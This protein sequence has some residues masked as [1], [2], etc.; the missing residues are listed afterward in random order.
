MTTQGIRLRNRGW[1]LHPVSTLLEVLESRPNW[2][3]K[4]WQRTFRDVNDPGAF[5][6]WLHMLHD[7]T[8]WS[9]VGEGYWRCGLNRFAGLLTYRYMKIFTCK[10]GEIDAL[11]AV[12][13]PE[14]LIEH[15]KELLPR[16]L[17]RN[18][19]ESE[20][21]DALKS[22]D[23]NPARCVSMLTSRRERTLVEKT[24]PGILLRGTE[25]W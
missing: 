8:Y 12:S 10:K 19:M 7:K 1:K 6:E 5:R 13:T 21:L 11:R 23:R 24:R 22:R 25:N 16:L 4:Q 15:E 3:S 20:L 17:I 14:Q 18:E 9:D 2:H